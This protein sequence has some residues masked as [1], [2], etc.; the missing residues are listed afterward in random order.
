MRKI[1]F[2][3]FAFASACYCFCQSSPAYNE[4]LKRL[5]TCVSKDT[6]NVNSIDDGTRIVG[7]C[8]NLIDTSLRNKAMEEK[9]ISGTGVQRLIQFEKV[10]SMDLVL[11]CPNFAAMIEKISAAQQKNVPHLPIA[12]TVSNALCKCL[13]L[14]GVSD[15]KNRITQNI[16]DCFQSSFLKH[17]DE[18]FRQYKVN[19]GNEDMLSGIGE[20]ITKLV[21]ENC[22]FYIEKLNPVLI[23][24]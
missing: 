15:S 18:L 1:V 6:A 22:T 8:M 7:D 21:M 2:L 16:T 11:K 23:K 17:Y 19:E 10:F 13:E 14:K 9:N 20:L 4:Y 3:L 24:N 5:C 12:D